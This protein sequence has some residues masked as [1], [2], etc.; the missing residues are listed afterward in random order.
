MIENSA[1]MYTLE[2]LVRERLNGT[3][4]IIL[5]IRNHVVIQALRL[6]RQDYN[7]SRLRNTESRLDILFFIVLIFERDAIKYYEI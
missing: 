3:Y 4:P 6:K 5:H 1:Y 2:F 7:P